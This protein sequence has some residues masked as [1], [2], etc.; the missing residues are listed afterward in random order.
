MMPVPQIVRS[1]S[2][3]QPVRFTLR[4]RCRR[5]GLLSSKGK[6]DQG[7]DKSSVEET[8]FPKQKA[9]GII[10]ATAEFTPRHDEYD[11]LG[12]CIV[13][14]SRKSLPSPSRVYAAYPLAETDL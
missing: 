9:L 3:P 14:T 12:F 4:I 13:P 5:D 11:C 1:S 6:F 8:F 7:W 2:T 10:P